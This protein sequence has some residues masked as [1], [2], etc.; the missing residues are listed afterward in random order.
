MRE[1]I[2]RRLSALGSIAA[3]ARRIDLRSA[4]TPR[5]T[6]GHAGTQGTHR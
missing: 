3:Q 2:V 5:S 4:A 1:V 6:V